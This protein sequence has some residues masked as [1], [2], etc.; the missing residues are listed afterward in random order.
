MKEEGASV[1][2]SDL[3]KFKKVLFFSGPRV[4]STALLVVEMRVLGVTC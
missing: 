3:E 4:W 1:T 2:S